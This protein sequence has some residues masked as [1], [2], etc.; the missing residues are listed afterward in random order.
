MVDWL[1]PH[2]DVLLKCVDIFPLYA[3]LLPVQIREFESYSHIRG[4]LKR[5]KMSE[6]KYPS[7]ARVNKFFPCQRNPMGSISCP[8]P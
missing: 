7:V 4:R 3:L 5:R 6:L 2:E 8:L 1:S